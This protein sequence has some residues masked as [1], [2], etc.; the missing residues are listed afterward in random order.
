MTNYARYRILNTRIDLAAVDNLRDPVRYVLDDTGKPRAYFR[1]RMNDGTDHI[2]RTP[3]D[4][5]TGSAAIDRC[6]Q[7]ARTAQ[8][9]LYVLLKK[10]YRNRNYT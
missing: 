7:Q 10:L 8:T 4:K 9:S 5:G 1:V 2:V 3:K 6:M